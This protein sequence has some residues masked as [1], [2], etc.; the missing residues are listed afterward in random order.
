MGRPL[1]PKV[2]NATAKLPHD[3]DELGRLSVWML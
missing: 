3:L 1:E 2:M